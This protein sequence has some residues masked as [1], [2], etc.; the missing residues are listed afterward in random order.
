MN[1]YLV[2]VSN[3]SLC[4][5][6]HRGKIFPGSR[7]HVFSCPCCCLVSDICILYIILLFRSSRLLFILHSG[8]FEGI[9]VAHTPFP[10]SHKLLSIPFVHFYLPYC[11]SEVPIMYYLVRLRLDECAW[12]KWATTLTYALDV[13]PL[14]IWWLWIRCDN[15]VYVAR[16]LN[17]PI[18]NDA[19]LSLIP[20]LKTIDE[21]TEM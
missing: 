20:C 2:I 5:G 9:G 14:W 17:A 4:T 12:H 13:F 1:I 7:M 11:L 16:I 8:W 10:F 19:F 3:R 21:S 18:S 15:R 6:T